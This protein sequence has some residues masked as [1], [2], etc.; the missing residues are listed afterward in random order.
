MSRLLRLGFSTQAKQ[1]F[2][3]CKHA[4]SSLSFLWIETNTLCK[5][6]NISRLPCLALDWCNASLAFMQACKKSNARCEARNVSKSAD[7]ACG[8][9]LRS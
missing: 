1:H 7:P 3:A 6:S 5:S 9:A 8:P 4:V 2:S